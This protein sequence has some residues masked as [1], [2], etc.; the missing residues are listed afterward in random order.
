M[1][2]KN[3]R[4]AVSAFAVLATAL[5]VSPPAARA[6]TYPAGM[7]RFK[8][9][10][11]GVDVNLGDQTIAT[12]VARNAKLARPFFKAVRTPSGVQV[13]RNNPPIKDKDPDDHGD[14]HPGIWMAFSDLG[15]HDFW[16][17]KGPRVE[18]EKL[19][20]IGAGVFETVNRYVDGDKT[21]A[22]ETNRF[23]FTPRPAGYLL[24]WETTLE[25]LD[26]G[27]YLG[28]V[29]EMGLGVR[30]ATP[31]TVKRGK[32]HI[33]NSLKGVDEKGTWGNAADWCDYAGEIDGKHVGV[34]VMAH[35]SNAYKTWFHSRDYGL[36]VANPTGE[37]AGAPAKWPLERGKPVQFRYGIFV[38]ESP[39]GD[40]APNLAAE[41]KTFAAATPYTGE[42]GKTQPAPPEPQGMVSLFD[43]KTLTGWDGDPRLWSVKDGT[44][45]GETTKENPANGNTFLFWTG[46]TVKDFEL[47][48]SFRCSDTNNSG[49]QY[50]SQRVKDAEAKNKWVAKG[51]QAEVRVD[52]ETPGFIYD[53][54][55][56]RGRMCLVG[57][58]AV[59]ENGKKNVTGIV[60]DPAT[61]RAALRPDGWND[62]VIIAKGSRVQ[63]FI[64]G[65]Q[66]IDFTDKDPK[67][68]LTEGVL[69][70][71]LHQGK[72]MWVEF[73]DI[74]LKQD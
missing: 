2:C 74:R 9:T 62:Y 52:T 23:T 58:Q 26:D 46:G 35:P 69:A 8:E 21:V 59:W 25:P 40:K 63:H 36:V 54:R 67:L 11:D 55:G 60:G 10:P 48:L 33:R 22:R 47:R 68:A 16:R 49:I 65:V 44:I 31:I 45:H 64:N 20:L 7:V 32:G 27:L 19:K 6:T 37:R 5:M 24:T 41:F 43:G 71:Q 51:Y 13:T 4:I 29:E 39:A 57:E 14:M 61:I 66:T 17:N 56:K 50:R 12:Y 1:T 42:P 3:F 18:Q 34:A 70:V 28:G 73:K 53:E 38:H 30:V 15:G 72:P